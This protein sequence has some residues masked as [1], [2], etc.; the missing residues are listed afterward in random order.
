MQIAGLILD[1]P[2]QLLQRGLD[3]AAPGMAQHH[4]QASAELLRRELDAADERRGH[5]VAGDANDEQ[6]SQT[7]IEDDLDRYPGIGA[8]QDGRERR[9][10]RGQLETA[11]TAANGV[12]IAV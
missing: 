2:L 12:A 6:G 11:R 4:H 5:D 9:L 3:G 7:L 1:R 10:T 8:P